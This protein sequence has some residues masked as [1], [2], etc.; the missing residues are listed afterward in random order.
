MDVPREK[1]KILLIP[2]PL[3]K[4]L[5]MGEYEQIQAVE[6]RNFLHRAQSD[7]PMYH[8]VFGSA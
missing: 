6:F 1:S 4:Q 7:Q 5:E 3:P 2:P 8:I